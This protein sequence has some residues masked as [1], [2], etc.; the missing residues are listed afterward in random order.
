M[1]DA[2]SQSAQTTNADSRA[3]GTQ[4][5]PCTRDNWS[6]TRVGVCGYCGKF[7]RSKKGCCACQRVRYCSKECFETDYESHNLTCFGR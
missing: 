6:Q 2:R 3:T 7:T 5:K 4:T 1:K